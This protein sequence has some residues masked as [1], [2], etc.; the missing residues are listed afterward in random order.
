M[1]TWVWD[2]LKSHR[3][4]NFSEGFRVLPGVKE[5]VGSSK[6]ETKLVTCFNRNFV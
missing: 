6:F 5:L 3:L 1:K 4:F 2:Q